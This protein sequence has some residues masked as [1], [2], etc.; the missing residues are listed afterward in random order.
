MSWK[1]DKYH[2]KLMNALWINYRPSIVSVDL[3]RGTSKIGNWGNCRPHYQ[4]LRNQV[5]LNIVCSIFTTGPHSIVSKPSLLF[6]CLIPKSNR[7]YSL[8]SNEG[9]H[10]KRTAI[11]SLIIHHHINVNGIRIVCNKTSF[12]AFI[13]IRVYCIER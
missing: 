2:N 11:I 6:A 7:I 9:R 4:W 8:Y 3:Y 5:G 12:L 10:R 1:L 13:N